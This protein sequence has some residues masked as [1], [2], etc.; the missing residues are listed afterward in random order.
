[1]FV[2]IPLDYKHARGKERVPVANILLIAVNVLVFSF[3]WFW[4]VGPGTSFLSVLMYGFSHAHF[5]HLLLNMWLLWV[6][7]TPVNRRIGNGYYL[8]AFFGAV[9]VLGLLARLFLHASLAGSSGAIFAVIAIG[10]ILIPAG[11]LRIAYLIFFPLTVLIGLVRLPKYWLHWFVRWGLFSVRAV[12]CLAFIP[13][14][15]L[16]SLFWSGWSWGH[17]AHLLGM[18]CGVVIVLMLP[19]RITI[20]GRST[21]ASS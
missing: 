19:T 21:A 6:F 4:A 18:V 17:V 20:P 9:V 5:W 11:L 8:L 2:L 12:W 3:G 13:L 14:I 7:G 15:E 1:M 10:L 16:W